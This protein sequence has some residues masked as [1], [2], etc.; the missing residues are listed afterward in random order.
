M[1]SKDTT[2]KC[3]IAIDYQGNPRIKVTKDCPQITLD[4]Y[5][6]DINSLMQLV[7]K[8]LELKESNE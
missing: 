3:V 2:I 1:S 4:C 5:T 7:D 8:E 6:D